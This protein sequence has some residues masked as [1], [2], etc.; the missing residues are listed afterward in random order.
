MKLELWTLKCNNAAAEQDFM[1]VHLLPSWWVEI[2]LHHPWHDLL[3]HRQFPASPAGKIWIYPFSFLLLDV[4]S[5]CQIIPRAAGHQAHS[6][7]FGGVE[8][9]AV[10]RN[11]SDPT[12]R[13]NYGMSAVRIPQAAKLICCDTKPELSS[14]LMQ[15]IFHGFGV[16]ESMQDTWSVPALTGQNPTPKYSR[17][18]GV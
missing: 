5:D 17:S 6:Q 12:S 15:M 11:I 9:A 2:T 10:L 13:K 7:C 4:I 16:E 14:G 8:L 3:G 18:S 1:P